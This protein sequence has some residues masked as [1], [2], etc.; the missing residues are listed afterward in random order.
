MQ[1]WTISREN[2]EFQLL[3]ALR[4]N[5]KKRRE[6]GEALV[7]GT[8]AIK[9]ALGAEIPLSRIIYRDYDKLS[10]W[11]KELI[12]GQVNCQTIQ[13]TEHLYRRLSQR[14]EPGEVIVTLPIKTPDLA[15]LHGI[16]DRSFLILDRPSDKGNL[17]TLIR[18]ANGFNLGGVILLGHGV[19]PWDPKVIRT[20]LGGIFHT[21]VVQGPSWQELEE[22]L[23]KQKDQQKF[24]LVGSDST[25]QNILPAQGKGSPFA[26]ALG[27]EAK[28]MSKR[29]WELCDRV[30][31]IPM[32]GQVN[33]LNIAS[34]GAILLW[35]LCS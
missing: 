1:S 17:G 34:A 28:G 11:A 5:R 32:N 6:R 26:L 10:D 31:R 4:D 25:G 7:E 27:N 8:E 29:L 22:W 3:E 35:S 20:S 2:G 16:K 12:Q 13:L 33:S 23:L 30:V 14:D 9:Q 24:E 15:S 19:D 18:T 21:P